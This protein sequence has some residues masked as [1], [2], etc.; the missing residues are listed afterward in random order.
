MTENV[1]RPHRD[2][3]LHYRTKSPRPRGLHLSEEDGAT[4]VTF[5]SPPEW[6]WAIQFAATLA[7]GLMQLSAAATMAAFVYRMARAAGTP[8]LLSALRPL[9]YT[10]ACFILAGVG[11][12]AVAVY[13]WW[14]RRRGAW[15][16]RTLTATGTSLVLRCFGWGKM[17]QTVW[18]VETIDSIELRPIRGNLNWTRTVADLYI[19]FHKGRR[20]KFRLSTSD[21]RL[22]AQIAKSLC[23]AL[24]LPLSHR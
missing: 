6:L 20:R 10:T 17:R 9:Y 18:P 8:E 4:V 1:P 14:S 7:M 23:M 5:P 3:I 15:D 19:R 21:P 12:L 2:E 22:P 16:A 24:G 11:W 13:S